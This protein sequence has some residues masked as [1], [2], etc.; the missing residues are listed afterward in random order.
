MANKYVIVALST[1][2]RNKNGFAGSFRRVLRIYN[3]AV[4]KMAN[5]TGLSSRNPQGYCEFESRRHCIDIHGNKTHKVQIL[6]S[7]H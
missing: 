6:F 1:T 4:G 5:P 3:D 7:R 2:Q